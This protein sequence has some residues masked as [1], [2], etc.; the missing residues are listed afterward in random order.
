L[1]SFD[2][3]LYIWF[4][5]GRSKT[6]VT[7]NIE[8]ISGFTFDGHQIGK[9]R[10]RSVDCYREASLWIQLRPCPLPPGEGLVAP[11]GARGPGWEK[12]Q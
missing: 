2:E 10:I 9:P 4:S 3:A 8:M 12:L 11:K 6:N 5:L 7:V 1:A